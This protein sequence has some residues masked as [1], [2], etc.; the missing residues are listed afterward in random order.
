M[1]IDS[2]TEGCLTH[3]KLSLVRLLKQEGKRHALSATKHTVLQRLF[4]KISLFSI[5]VKPTSKVCFRMVSVPPRYSKYRLECFCTKPRGASLV[6]VTRSC[7]HIDNSMFYSVPPVKWTHLLHSRYCM[8]SRNS[9]VTRTLWTTV[10]ERLTKNMRSQQTTM[11]KA[12]SSQIVS[13]L[14]RRAQ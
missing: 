12:K 14:L 9:Q 1:P 6:F 2:W 3:L 7:R 10:M 4:S 11:R 13:K 5:Q 8:W